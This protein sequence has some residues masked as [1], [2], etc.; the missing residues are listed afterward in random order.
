MQLTDAQVQQG[1]ASL[2]GWSLKDDK[3][4]RSCKFDDFVSAFGFMAQVAMLAEKA[5]HHPEWFNVYNRVDLWLT[6]HDVAGISERDFELA[7][8][9]NAIMPGKA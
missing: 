5:D 4:F 3:L 9:I 8:A 6:T 1:I 2:P 7:M